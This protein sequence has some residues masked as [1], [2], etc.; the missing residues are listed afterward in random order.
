MKQYLP[1][2]CIAVIFL[3]IKLSNFGIR[4]SDTNIYFYTGY[5]LLQGQ[6]LYKDIFFT[7]FPLLPYISSIYFFLL[8]GSL[9]LFYL[10][11]V[12]EVLLTSFIIYHIILKQT[13]NVLYSTLSVMLYAFSFIVLSTSDHQTGV[14]AASLFAVL[15]YYFY[16]SNRFVLQGIFIALSLL[17]KAYF[18]PIFLTYTIVMIYKREGE[19][20]KFYFGFLT[21]TFIILLPTFILAPKELIQDVLTYSLTRSQGVEKTR[22]IWF[23]VIHDLLLFSLLI[24][25]IIQIRKNLFF[26]ILS[27]LGILFIFLYKD[28]YYL[29]LN[30]LV[31]FLCLSLPS[32]LQ[33]LKQKITLQKLLASTI[34]VVFILINI[35]VYL[36]SYATLQKLDNLDEIVA[37]V[38]KENPSFI[39]G[40]NDLAPAL[41][42]LTTI[43]LLENV[44]DTNPNIFRK[45]YLR[46]SEMTR[47]A[48]EQDTLFVGHGMYYPQA[49][50]RQDITDEIFDPEQLPVSCSIKGLF[51][52]Q[53]EGAQNRIVL[54]RC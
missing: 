6:V 27:V 30:F 20:W 42:Y 23:F 8:G 11:P 51:P 28:V 32:L 26:G 43:P 39:Y 33:Y 37:L 45:G 17:T 19:W 50:I 35:F 40:T 4:L 53:M 48:I 25:N 38:K 18:L 16:T 3:L 21:T 9:K 44:I 10:T 13:K 36:R 24:W 31:P 46:A 2:L 52:V 12:I 7:N 15:S 5:Q 22:L 41:S 47:K 14:F 54:F 29:Y 34:I 1:F 49:N